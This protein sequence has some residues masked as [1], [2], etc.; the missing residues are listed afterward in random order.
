MLWAQFPLWAIW[1][2]S[3]G[4]GCGDNSPCAW[5]MWGVHGANTPYVRSQLVGQVG[6]QICLV[7]ARCI[8]AHGA[9]LGLFPCRNFGFGKSCCT[10]PP[11]G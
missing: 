10:P 5:G 1:E 11:G 4:T 2:H 8:V 9:I 7:P 6:D 3:M